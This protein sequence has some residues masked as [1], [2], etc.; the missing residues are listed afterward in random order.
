MEPPKYLSFLDDPGAY[1]FEPYPE[2][3]PQRLEPDRRMQLP[4]EL[5][6]EQAG[7]VLEQVRQVLSGL[8]LKLSLAGHAAARLA[9]A[10]ELGIFLSASGEQ[11]VRSGWQVLG[12][13]QPAPEQPSAVVAVRR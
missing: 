9:G 6:P 10:R 1:E 2:G 13:G 11:V 7:Q 3:S 12:A 5:S 4:P 8:G